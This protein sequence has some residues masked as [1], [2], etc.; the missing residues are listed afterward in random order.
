MRARIAP[1]S[2]GIFRSSMR[3]ISAPGAV[4]MPNDAITPRCAAARSSAIDSSRSG[5][6]DATA[7]FRNS[8]ISGSSGIADLS[9]PLPLHQRERR[10]GVGVALEERLDGAADLD[11]RARVAREIAEHADAAGLG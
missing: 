4:S 1:P 10:I 6:G 2:T 3:A 7:A 11:G 9:D 5:G 8:W